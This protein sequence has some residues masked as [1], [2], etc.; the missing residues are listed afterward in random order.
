MGDR[1]DEKIMYIYKGKL[2]TLSV[3]FEFYIDNE[4]P[5]YSSQD[6]NDISLIELENNGMIVIV[7]KDALDKLGYKHIELCVWH[8]LINTIYKNVYYADMCVAYWYGFSNT[9]SVIDNKDREKRLED[10][11]VSNKDVSIPI[12]SDILNKLKFIEI[13]EIA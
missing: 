2:T 1:T 7:S 6:T 13:G 11:L 8:R 9:I 12:K 4:I 10:L 3:K 5:I